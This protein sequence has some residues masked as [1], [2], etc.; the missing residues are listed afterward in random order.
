MARIAVIGGSGYAG[1]H[2]V[3]EAVSRGHT[4]LA[5]ARRIPPE[6]HEGAFYIEGSLT[7][8]PGLLAQLEGVDVVVSAVAPRGDMR[9][10]VR[11][12]LEALAEL[13]PEGVRLGVV[14][15]AGGSLVTEGGQRVVDLPSFAPDYR[16]ESLEA[17]G[18]LED[19][20]AGPPSVDWFYVHPARAF[21]AH[22]PGER[23]GSYRTGG[24]VLVTDAAGESYISGADLAVA[25]VDE[26]EHPQH[27]RKRFTVGY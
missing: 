20:E 6:R 1:R 9:G 16:A 14:G 23:T 24:D 19:L 7:D 2:I 21:G 15:G 13:L 12:N 18:I 25:V 11:P 4:V 8:V 10:L 26:I 17:I 22:N 3:A 27:S 5:I